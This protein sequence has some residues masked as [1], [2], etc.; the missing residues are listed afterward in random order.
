M[1]GQ[2]GA[3]VSQT[4]AFAAMSAIAAIGTVAA[5]FLWPANDPDAVPHEH[6]DLPEDDPHRA[7][8]AEG[9]AHSF[10]I[11]DVHEKWPRQ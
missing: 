3:D 2:L 1:V 5:L 10:V 11:D 8:H 6:P 4:A 7:A 9:N